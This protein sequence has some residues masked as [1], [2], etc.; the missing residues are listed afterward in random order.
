MKNVINR[1]KV[2][3]GKPRDTVI[4]AARIVCDAGSLWWSDVRP[5]CLSRRLTSAAAW[6]RAADIDITRA[7]LA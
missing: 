3:L 1:L 7:T 4:D 5:V 6:A 2:K